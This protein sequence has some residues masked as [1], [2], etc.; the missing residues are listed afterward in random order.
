M[1]IL[2]LQITVPLNSYSKRAM[3]ILKCCCCCLCNMIPLFNFTNIGSNNLVSL[4]PCYSLFP[5]LISLFI[6][7]LHS[8]KV[9][10]KDNSYAGRSFSVLDTPEL[11]TARRNKQNFS[12]VS[13]FLSS[14]TFYS[15]LE[16]SHLRGLFL[17]FIIN[18]YL[19]V[20]L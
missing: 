3:K 12:Q 8:F 19:I 18:V 2:L 17:N 10:Y 13:Y 16:S 20:K 9:H 4:F 5:L 1:L 11:V 15:F 7:T 14:L 6:S